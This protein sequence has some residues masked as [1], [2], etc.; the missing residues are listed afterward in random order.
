MAKFKFRFFLIPNLFSSHCIAKKITNS[1]YGNVSAAPWLQGFLLP[2]TLLT[3]LNLVPTASLR[4]GIS[5][6]EH[7]C[8]RS[9]V[10]VFPQAGLVAPQLPTWENSWYHHKHHRLALSNPCSPSK[11][12]FKHHVLGEVLP[13]P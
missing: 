3:G 1:C 9:H 4:R 2:L 7:N 6:P 8:L 5:I 13:R 12:W 11:A 10:R